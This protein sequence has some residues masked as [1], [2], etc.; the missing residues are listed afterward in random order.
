[1]NEAITESEA[2]RILDGQPFSRLL[3]TRIAEVSSRRAVLELDVTERLHQQNGFV[4][5]G[6]L[7]YLAD[8]T[9]TYAGGTVL[10]AQVLTASVDV[11]YLTTADSG[12][13]RAVST[14]LHHTSRRAICDC[15]IT[16]ERP[17][18][19]PVTCALARGTVLAV[20]GAP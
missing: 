7:A 3:G 5:G 15:V 13:L 16:I 19:E 18:D 4:H 14:V 12:T 20:Q 6:V 8:N 1:M 11:E 10:G 2:A 9:L 17:D